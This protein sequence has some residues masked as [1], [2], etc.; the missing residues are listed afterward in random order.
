M[1]VGK[2]VTEPFVL[3]KG[4]QLVEAFTT[5]DFPVSHL[6]QLDSELCPC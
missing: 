5:V 4:S 3:Q 1:H 2:I 6:L